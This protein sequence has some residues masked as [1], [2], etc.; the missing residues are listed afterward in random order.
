MENERS[1][2]CKIRKEKID[3]NH[4]LYLMNLKK[5]ICFL[6]ANENFV[7]SC[8]K[9]N[10]FSNE[11]ITKMDFEINLCENNFIDNT[12]MAKL[13]Y[14]K[15]NT[16]YSICLVKCT[17]SLN[18]PSEELACYEECENNFYLRLKKLNQ[19]FYK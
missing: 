15:S 7:S 4:F 12:N 9:N 3:F 6:K 2:L 1:S 18:T 13:E 19:I 5:E 10:F 8:K 11:F 16:K 14:N 17:E